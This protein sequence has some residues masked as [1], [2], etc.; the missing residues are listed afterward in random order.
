MSEVD[1]GGSPAK[2]YFGGRDEEVDAARAEND[3][4]EKERAEFKQKPRKTETKR[5]NAEDAAE[6][7][8]DRADVTL[9]ESEAVRDA[10]AVNTEGFKPESADMRKNVRTRNAEETG[11]MAPLDSDPDAEPAKAD[12]TAREDSSV[13]GDEDK[14]EVKKPGVNEKKKVR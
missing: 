8:E 10:L 5:T 13:V 2:P 11:Q 9:A 1:F 14:S 12:P 7:A 4:L 3:R 6:A